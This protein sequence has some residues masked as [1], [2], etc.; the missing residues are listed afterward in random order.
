MENHDKLPDVLLI[1]LG[2]EVLNGKLFKPHSG[3]AS[4]P[5]M[6][7][8]WARKPGVRVLSASCVQAEALAGHPGQIRPLNL[9]RSDDCAQFLVH[10]LSSKFATSIFFV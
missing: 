4:Q 10:I 9:C 3:N 8:S 1:A 2:L 7:A 5:E 6:F